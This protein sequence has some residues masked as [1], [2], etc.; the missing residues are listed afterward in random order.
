M[1]V[2]QQSHQGSG[3]LPAVAGRGIRHP[4]ELSQCERAGVDS[5]QTGQL[6]DQPPGVGAAIAVASA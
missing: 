5:Q 2:G 6:V 4:A 1:A 3:V